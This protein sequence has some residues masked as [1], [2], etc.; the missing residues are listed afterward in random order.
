MSLK[1]RFSVLKE[2]LGIFSIHFVHLYNSSLEVEGVPDTLKIARA[3]PGHKSGPTDKIDNYR[4]ISVLPLFSKVFE[5]L[6]LQRINSFIMRHNLLT[7]SQFGFRKGYSTTNRY[8]ITY[9]CNRSISSK[10]FLCL[11]LFRPS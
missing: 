9:S 3:N 5:K 2:N 10:S 11:I 8:K 6:T 1:N 4:P 7:P